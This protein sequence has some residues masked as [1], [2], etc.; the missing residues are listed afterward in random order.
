MCLSKNATYLWSIIKRIQGF[1]SDAII[2]LAHSVGFCVDILDH[3][4]IKVEN[5]I[6]I[7]LVV[8]FMMIYGY[9]L[10]VAHCCIMAFWGK[11]EEKKEEQQNPNC[12]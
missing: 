1:Q 12:D 9:L 4:A 11:E 6:R 7:Q 3:L 8:V 10:I 5:Q 2:G